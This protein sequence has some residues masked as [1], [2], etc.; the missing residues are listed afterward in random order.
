MK[1]CFA[2]ANK[3][4]LREAAEILGPDYILFSSAQA[5]VTED[6]PETGSTF[7]ENSLQKASYVREH[8]GIDCFADDSGLEVDA[9]GGAPGVYSARYNGDHNFDR[10]M[11]KVLAE[12]VALG[13]DA[14]RTA[15]FRCVVTLA[16]DGKFYHF[17]GSVEGRI[18]F[19]KAG[20]GGF[21]YDPIFIPDVNP[22]LRPDGTYEP[23]PNTEN[24]TLSQIS[25]DAKNSISHRG[26][27]LRKMAA[28]LKSLK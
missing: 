23:L 24:L 6:I 18:A 21:G 4:K 2:T 3:G 25:E 27:A 14:D 20:N 15:R 26:E 9:L 7:V 8:C 16:L 19:E 10:N 11:N 1:I 22:V 17:D 28:F 12:L 13:P 5:G